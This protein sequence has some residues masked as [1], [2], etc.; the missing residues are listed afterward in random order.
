MSFSAV[1]AAENFP[2]FF[3][4]FLR[5]EKVLHKKWKNDN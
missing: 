4:N 3:E 5:F 2:E 1:A